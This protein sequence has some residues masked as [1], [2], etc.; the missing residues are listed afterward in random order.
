MTAADGLDLCAAYIERHP[1]AAGRA[2]RDVAS[3]DAAALLVALRPR[4]AA[5]VLAQTGAMRAS[6]LVLEMDQ[7]A[8]AAILAELPDAEA[9]AILRLLEAPPRD[10]LLGRLPDLARRHVADSLEYA[11]D[12]VGSIMTRAIVAL[13]AS[14]RTADALEALRDNGPV[15]P[16]CVFVTDGRH[17]VAGIVS[18]MQLLCSSSRARLSELIDSAPPLVAS[19]TSIAAVVDHD[20]WL[21]HSV[22]PVVNRERQLIGA[23]SYSSLRRHVRQPAHASQPATSSILLS[24]SEDMVDSVSGLWGLMLDAPPARSRG[25][26]Q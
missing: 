4:V 7:E 25:G 1:E 2:L 23:L 14:T 13:E 8:A 12:S 11:A 18:A 9:A 26:R 24:M 10:A 6:R 16:G 15:E 3:A 22:L 21:T 19:R 20:A 5:R 17:G